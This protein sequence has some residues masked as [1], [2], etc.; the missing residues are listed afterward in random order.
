LERLA[1]SGEKISEAVEQLPK[2]HV[3]K[4]N[5]PVE[6]N[7]IYSLIQRFRATAEQEGMPYDMTDGVK[8]TTPEGWVHVRASN[9]ESMIRVIVETNNDND[10]RVLLDWA[11]DSLRT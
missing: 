4:Y 7:R 5:I 11:R 9:T 3:G 1:R 6:P 2:L 8:V 10:A